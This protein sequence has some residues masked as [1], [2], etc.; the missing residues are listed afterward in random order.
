MSSEKRWG[1]AGVIMTLV[2]VAATYLWPNQKW[3]GL[4]SLCSASGV[5]LIWVILEI[6]KYVRNKKMSLFLSLLAGAL[7]GSLSAALI[8]YSVGNTDNKNQPSSS[9]GPSQYSA[10][11]TPSAKEIAN[12]LAKH[13]PTKNVSPE[14]SA[15]IS[16]NPS[17]RSFPRLREDSEY[18]VVDIGGNSFQSRVEDLRKSKLH[19][20]HFGEQFD[21]SIYLD[22]ENLLVDADLR[23]PVGLN[24]Q[25]KISRN[26]FVVSA[27]GWDYNSNDLAFE[28]V[29][30]KGNPVLQLMFQGDKKLIIRGM[31]N[32]GN[33]VLF[34]NDSGIRAMPLN[35][36]QVEKYKLVPIFEYPAWKYPG[37]YAS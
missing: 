17:S 23:S 21:L 5:L 26:Q 27:A 13:L 4:I 34:I 25:V 11:K 36:A 7:L 29:D 1:L 32:G 14:R 18:I 6:N 3:I 33:R 24:P 8:W 12:E 37:K 16:N 19:P 2:T 10:Y 20:I 15:P 9:E 31:F 28:V 30:N 22:G 35:N